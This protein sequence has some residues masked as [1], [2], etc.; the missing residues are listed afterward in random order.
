M[1]KKHFNALKMIK[2]Q[3]EQ[4]GPTQVHAKQITLF[5]MVHTLCK[6]FSE[7]LKIRRLK[8]GGDL[9]SNLTRIASSVSFRHSFP[10][11]DPLPLL[12]FK[13]LNIYTSL[14][15]LEEKCFW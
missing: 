12:P 11:R 14:K 3:S 2:N 5:R 9:A 15:V 13:F 10:F 8:F 1:A 4:K 6:K 7:K